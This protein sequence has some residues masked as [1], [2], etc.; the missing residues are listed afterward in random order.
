VEYGNISGLA[1][2]MARLKKYRIHNL[3]FQSEIPIMGVREV[4]TNKKNILIRE[5]ARRPLSKNGFRKIHR[6]S[7]VQCFKKNEIFYV[8]FQRGLSTIQKSTILTQ[9]ILPHILATRGLLL[10]HGSVIQNKNK[11]FLILGKSGSGKSTLSLEAI[12]NKGLCLGDEAAIVYKNKKHWHVTS[13][14]STLR[15]WQKDTKN[16]LEKAVLTLPLPKTSH[17][18]S[19]VIVLQKK[20][21]KSKLSTLQFSNLQVLKEL[22]THLFCPENLDADKR[23]SLFET[24]S[25]FSTT[26]TPVVVQYPHKKANRTLVLNELLEF[27]KME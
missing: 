11:T 21:R 4:S 13:A 27:R 18:L 15:Y 2:K 25:D 12:K 8:Y 9:D 10:L 14:F 23:R 24:L 16:S 3:I 20:S 6:F 26:L 17:R 19:R 5:A 22:V 7:A 1:Q